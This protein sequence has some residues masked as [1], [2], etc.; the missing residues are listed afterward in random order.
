MIQVE[1]LTINDFNNQTEVEVATTRALYFTVKRIG[2]RK[3]VVEDK[4]EFYQGYKEY[5]SIQSVKDDL[6]RR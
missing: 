4:I 3:Y 5:N 6:I 2:I 1:N